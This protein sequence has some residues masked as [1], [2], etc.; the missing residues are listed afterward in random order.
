MRLKKFIKENRKEIDRCIAHALSMNR[1][2]YPN[3]EERRQWI[4]N[5]ESLYRW[6]LS[7]G[8]RI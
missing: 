2:P 3:D 8:V 1:N 5:D 7:E 6:A 4:L